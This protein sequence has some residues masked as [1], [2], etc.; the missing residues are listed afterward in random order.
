MSNI[1]Y[2]RHVINL[3]YFLYILYIVCF[4]AVVSHFEINF[5][6]Q[7]KKDPY[8]Y[9]APPYLL[10]NKSYIAIDTNEKYPIIWWCRRNYDQYNIYERT[11]P[12]GN[13]KC[14]IR[15]YSEE[16]QTETA[17]YVY[18]PDHLTVRPSP[19]LPVNPSIGIWGILFEESPN[20]CKEC[21]IN[22]VLTS[23]N[24]SSTYS[25]Y[26]TV[27]FPLQW[28][29]SLNNITSK[30][31]FIETSKKNSFLKELSPIMYLQ[32]DCETSTQRDLYIKELMKYQSIDSYGKCL[33]NKN[34]PQ[35]L[36]R[37]DHVLKFNSVEILR[38]IAKYKF[39]IAIENAVCEDYITEKFW[40]AI[41]LGV[42]PIY[43]GSPSIRD[44]F[45]NN[46]SAILLQDFPTPELMST[47]IDKVLQDD[48]L[49]EEYLEH[50]TKGIISNKNLIK[51]VEERSYQLH[52][53]T[54][55]EKFQCFLCEK[56]YKLKE[57]PLPYSVINRSH[58][59]C[60]APISAL[61]QNVND[62]WVSLINYSTET[63]R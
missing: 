61:T 58:Y 17:A 63:I 15:R 29:I 24:Y 1:Y 52:F 5:N 41:H 3:N 19:L 7:D 44:W 9:I 57:G 12:C 35:K 8:Y 56:L 30:V 60:P 49:Y 46:K 4:Y 45:P 22:K 53:K 11:I 26:S 14:L 18:H 42:V 55:V 36:L 13:V 38:L 10:N 28:M 47:H 54:S 23:F 20:Y 62:E 37:R 25:R 31:Y 16:I 40:R 6:L 39:I 43:F 50:K 2:K 27:P 32:S 48:N 51:E 21:Y 34:M 59:N 33:N